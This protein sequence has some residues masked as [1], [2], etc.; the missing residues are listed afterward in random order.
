MNIG[1]AERRRHRVRA[2]WTCGVAVTEHV[3]VPRTV[4]AKA[5][6]PAT[7]SLP[8]PTLIPTVP[9][10]VTFVPFASVSVTVCVPGCTCGVTVTEHVAV[11]RTVC[12]KVHVPVTT[13]LP[14]PTAM[15]TVPVGVDFGPL[16]VSV[17]ETFT[18]VD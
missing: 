2:P 6:V 13:S 5:H 1:R 11:P 18:V 14:T 16:S 8:T 9:V 17:M 3:A 4:C 12:A 15:P 7:A 10:G